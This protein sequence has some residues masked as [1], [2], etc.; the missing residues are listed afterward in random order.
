VGMMLAYLGWPEEERRIEAAVARAI[1]ERQCT[2]DVGGELG[3]RAAS[4]W[5]REAIRRSFAS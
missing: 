3:T 4:E 2:K 1:D 5:V